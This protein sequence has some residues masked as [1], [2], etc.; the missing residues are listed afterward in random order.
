MKSAI[1][2]IVSGCAIFGA[3][4]ASADTYAIS[5]QKGVKLCKAEL[6]RLQPALQSYIV[7]YED[8]L[9]SLEQFSLE[10]NA[11]N[12]EGRLDKFTCTVDRK[13]QTA[14]VTLKKRRGD[15][16]PPVYA[17]KQELAQKDGEIAQR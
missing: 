11:K 15:F 4:A 3:A 10:F 14:V 17:G 13:A 6:A 5:L 7:D 12:A 9:S 8:S 2:A 16:A 1:A